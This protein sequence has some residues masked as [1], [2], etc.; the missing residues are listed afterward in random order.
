MKKITRGQLDSQ[1][2]GQLRGQL[3]SQL[4]SQLRS[5]LY[6]QLESQLYD[7]LESQ[8]ESQLYSQ[9]QNVG[10]KEINIETKLSIFQRITM[11]FKSLF[12]MLMFVSCG[13]LVI[14]T[15]DVT[16]GPDFKS[17]AKF[18]DDRYGK[19][20]EQSEECFLD[21]REYFTVRLKFDTIEGIIDFCELSYEEYDDV[22][23]CVERHVQTASS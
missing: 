15:E 20:T 3:G 22:M 7:Q 21:Y 17:A 12:I 6:D 23:D 10:V 13:E 2:R 1:L 5:Q 11:F 16:V 9:L 4:E 18:C 8:L 14:K 19:N